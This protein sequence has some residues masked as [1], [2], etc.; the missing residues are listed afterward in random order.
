MLICCAI[1]AQLICVFDFVFA[2]IL[3]SH[4]ATHIVIP[5]M[6]DCAPFWQ[7]FHETLL[8]SINWVFSQKNVFFTQMYIVIYG[9]FD[10]VLQIFHETMCNNILIY[11]ENVW[12]FYM[13][14]HKNLFLYHQIGLDVT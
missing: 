9:T 3:F 14:N 2:K 10:S 5:V 6:S 1:T 4:D 12:L 7:K 13:S 8:T 11:F